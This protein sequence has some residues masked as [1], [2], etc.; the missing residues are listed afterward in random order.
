MQVILG[1]YIGT[2]VY[3][4]LVLRLI[5]ISAGEAEGF[6]PVVSVG[7][8]IILALVCV[9]LLIY[10]ITHITELIQSTNI[11]EIAHDN[12]AEIA[13]NLDDLAEASRKIKDPEEDPRWRGLLAETPSVAQATSS[14]YVQDMNID[15]LLAAVVDERTEVVDVPP[16]PGKFV[17]SGLPIARV[18]PSSDGDFDND[19]EAKANRAFVFGKERSLKQDLG[20][21]LRQL[22]DIALKGLSPGINDPTTAMQALDRVEAVFITLGSKALPRRVQRRTVNDREVLVR[23]G[24]LTFDD[25]VGLAFD[26]V[27]RAAFATGQVAVLERMLEILGRAIRANG[28]SERQSS[29]WA[30]AFAI[31]RLAPEQIPDPRDAANL[32]VQAVE[33]VPGLLLKERVAVD[34]DLEQ[35][36][37]L[38]ENLEGG[39]QVR[40]AIEAGRRQLEPGTRSSGQAKS[41]S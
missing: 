6:H 15:S 2:F 37:S 35:L 24:Y 12:T 5:T 4:L 13:G 16:G 3:S 32:M 28:I 39:E 1:F 20:F 17:S 21:G 8:A 29:L 40:K 7:V 41:P 34:G 36:V 18:W 30:R 11:I 31:A 22:T 25:L 19:A 23:I 38:S 14:G 33:I 27:R 9:A 10:F 26:Q